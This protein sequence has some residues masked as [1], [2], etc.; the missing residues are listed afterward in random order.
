MKEAYIDSAAV[1]VCHFWEPFSAFE[2][3]TGEARERRDTRGKE[4][5]GERDR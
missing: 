5:S 2:G 4:G 3:E 1:L